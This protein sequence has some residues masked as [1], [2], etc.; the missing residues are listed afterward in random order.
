M[1]LQLKVKGFGSVNATVQ[2]SAALPPN[3][4]T[5]NTFRNAAVNLAPIAA[6]GENIS[7]YWSS[8]Q[9]KNG[10]YVDWKFY[11][12]EADARNTEFQTTVITESVPELPFYLRGLVKVP[13][14]MHSY[15]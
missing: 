3:G 4:V 2:Q 1:R 14:L 5:R 12:G 11:G 13:N 7:G 10:F 9:L 15:T 6:M 8:N